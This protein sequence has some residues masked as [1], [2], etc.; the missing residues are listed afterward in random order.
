MIA[1]TD[2]WHHRVILIDPETKKVISQYGHGGQPEAPQ[3]TSMS[4]TD[5]SSSGSQAGALDAERTHSMLF[6]PAYPALSRA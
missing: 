6:G 1:V 3:A 4:P 5:S 2:D